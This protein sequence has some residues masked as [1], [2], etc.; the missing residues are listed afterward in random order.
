[1]KQGSAE[2]SCMFCATA[3]NVLTVD[4]CLFSGCEMCLVMTFAAQVNFE[5]PWWNNQSHIAIHFFGP[6]DT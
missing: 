6:C 5:R 2:S 1:M 3:Y 4:G